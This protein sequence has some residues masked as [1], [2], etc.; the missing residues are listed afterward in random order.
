MIDYK[1]MFWENGVKMAASSFPGVYGSLSE[2]HLMFTLDHFHGEF[3]ERVN[4]FIKAFKDVKDRNAELKDIQPVFCRWFLSDIANQQNE[5]PEN[6]LNCAQ[7]VIGQPPLDGSKVALWI[8]CVSGVKCR[9]IG[10]NFYCFNHLTY[11]HFWLGDGLCSCENPQEA[12]EHFLNDYESLLENEGCSIKDNCLRTWFFVRDIDTN[13]KGLVEGRNLV[14]KNLGLT[15]S[16]HFIA[17]TGISGSKRDPEERVIF[18][19]MA[20]KGLAPKQIKYLKAKDYLNPTIEY[21][22]AFERGTS[23]DYGDRRHVIIS[24]TASI[25]KKGEILHSGN[26]IEQAYRMIENVAAL[27]EEAE[28]GWDEVTHI[29]LYLRDFSDYEN[30]KPII[31]QQFPNIP[32]IMIQAPVCRPGWLIEMECEAIKSVEWA[33]YAPF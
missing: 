28:S 16:T 9:R 33:Q 32:V 8:Y 18:N 10:D 15:P 26:V 30:I 29:I 17:S 31:L 11:S 1:T 6:A 20:V 22:V 4:A 7:S 2:Y 27:L 25:N 5:I 3:K 19:A 13:Y 21:G 12:T 24:G 14:F 23:V